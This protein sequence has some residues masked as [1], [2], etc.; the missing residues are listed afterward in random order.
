VK[1]LSAFT[2]ASK[3]IVKSA[4]STVT[5][6]STSRK[7]R[8]IGCATRSQRE[9]ATSRRTDCRSDAS[10]K[11]RTPNMAIR[12]A[13]AT[14]GKSDAT[15]SGSGQSRMRTSGAHASHRRPRGAVT[16]NR[17]TATT[18]A[19]S[20]RPTATP[21]PSPNDSKIIDRPL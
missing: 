18:A 2:P 6:R 1:R 8:G 7:I 21:V 14:S 9:T 13:A 5:M 19:T 16:A 12:G 20:S 17:A 3:R 11:N 4:A 15:A 10:R